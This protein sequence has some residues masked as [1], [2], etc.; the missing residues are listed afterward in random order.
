MPRCV[1]LSL[2]LL[3]IR[4]ELA[5]AAL[6][7]LAVFALLWQILLLWLASRLVPDR[8]PDEVYKVACDDGWVIELARY[9]SKGG[10]P[11]LPPV[12][13]CHGI[14]AN[15]ISLDLTEETSLPRYLRSRGFD[16][17]LLDLR[18]R[19]GSARPPAGRGAYDYDF[20]DHARHDVKAAIDLVRRETGAPKVAWVGHSMGGMSIYGHCELHGDEALQ[21]AVVCGSPVAWP[22]P[23]KVA[24]FA[25]FARLHRLPALY[26]VLAARL[27]APLAGYWHPRIAK[28][29]VNPK[30]MDGRLMR[31]GLARA[32][33]NMSNRAIQ[34]LAR[35]VTTDELKGGDHVF[36]RDLSRITVPWFAIGG[37]VDRLVPP[38]NVKAG[39]DRIG[40]TDK[41]W[42]LAGKD[43]GCV[44]DYGHIDLLLGSRCRD[45]IYKPIAEFLEAHPLAAPGPDQ[46]AS[47]SNPSSVSAAA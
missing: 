14:G 23:P 45:E 34:Q 39:F 17:W 12:I 30:N 20:A 46:A 3:M 19:G 32:L 5:L 43:E 21:A 36:F 26:Y 37:R 25:R 31:V 42:L 7:A 24:V 27:V 15:S 2:C 29:I 10:A 11:H 38:E 47:T 28:L 41:K 4:I 44:E 8:A 6:A 9:K 22:R 40:S 1:I 35:W 18:G 16:S 33:A 13:C